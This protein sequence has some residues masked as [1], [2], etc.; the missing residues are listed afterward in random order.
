MPGTIFMETLRRG[1]RGMLYWGAGMALYALITVSLVQD[2]DLLKQFGE[3]AQQLPL[4]LL[5]A[6][7]ASEEMLQQV[8]PT[9]FLGWRYFG[10]AIILVCIYAIIAGLNISA[11]EEEAGILDLVLTLP[12]ARGR[13]IVEK[14]AAYALL[15]TGIIALSF[16]GILVGIQATGQDMDIGLLLQATINMLPAA[17]LVLAFTALVGGVFRNKALVTA[18]AA[19]FLIGSY[20]LDTL[21]GMVSGS[22]FDQLRVISFFRYYDAN[23]VMLH[24]LQWGNAALLV[25]V[26]LVMVAGG[27]WG[28][29]RRDIGG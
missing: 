6:L 25:V 11:N 16:I 19:L 10:F 26:A 1:W 27:L 24:G 29:Q 18:A 4:G 17:L 23:G 5:Q 2:A 8:T 9:G 13:V 3:L 20:F 7:G 12:V 21:G 28:F 22:F 14:W 15:L